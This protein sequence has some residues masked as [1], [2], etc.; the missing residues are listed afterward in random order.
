MDS[1]RFHVSGQVQGVFFRA[2]TRREAL[3]LG[4]RGYARNLSD[5]R[6]EVVACGSSE[7]VSALEDW[8]WQG[9]PAARV[10]DVARSEYAGAVADGFVVS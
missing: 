4:L 5:G 3:K 1:V 6:V 2:S 7:A 8:L 10:D 9:P